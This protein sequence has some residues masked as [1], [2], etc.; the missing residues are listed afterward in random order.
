MKVEIISV[1]RTETIELP[2]ETDFVG[3]K[4]DLPDEHDCCVNCGFPDEL[5]GGRVECHTDQR[6][7]DGGV[8]V[9]VYSY[10]LSGAAKALSL[11]GYD[12]LV[13]CDVTCGDVRIIITV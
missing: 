11:R 7:L 12:G 13:F 9:T 5:C 2:P 6:K 4:L 10:L 8:T 3:V 1:E